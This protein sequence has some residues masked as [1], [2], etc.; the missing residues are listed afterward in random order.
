MCY[1]TNTKGK[2]AIT[3]D[4]L[5]AKAKMALWC[6]VGMAHWKYWRS[7]SQAVDVHPQ[8][9]GFKQK[10]QRAYCNL[11]KRLPKPWIKK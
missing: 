1:Q 6:G 2:A 5:W 11:L 3:P 8:R 10:S 9:N 4:R 7:K